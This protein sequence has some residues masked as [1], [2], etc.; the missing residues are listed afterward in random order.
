MP[1]KGSVKERVPQRTQQA[2]LQLPPAVIEQRRNPYY[3]AER[4]KAP[5][6]HLVPVSFYLPAETSSVLTLSPFNQTAAPA[7][8]IPRRASPG[9]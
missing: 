1:S 2:C 5:L 9:Q 6:Y 3:L 7:T 4:S 8:H